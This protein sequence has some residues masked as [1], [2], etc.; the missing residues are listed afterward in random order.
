MGFVKITEVNLP[1]GKSI[2]G[3]YKV[4][5]RLGSGWEGEVYKIYA[6]KTGIE[7]AAKLFYP[8]RNLRDKSAKRYAKQLHKLSQSSLLIQYPPFVLPISF[9]Q[10]SLIW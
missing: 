5:S 7:K 10:W 9:R 6:V 4:I 2:A 1:V 8:Q 3:K